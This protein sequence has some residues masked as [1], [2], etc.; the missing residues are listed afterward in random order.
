FLAKA[1]LQDQKQIWFFSYP[2]Q[3]AR[4]ITSDSSGYSIMSLSNDGATIAVSKVDIISSIWSFNPQNKEMTQVVSEN[5]MQQG[6]GG[7]TH[8]PD[9]RILFA[10]TEGTRTHLWTMSEEGR[11]EKV[12]LGEGGDSIH[13]AISPDGKFVVFSSNNQDGW[14]IWKADID[15][16]NAVQLTR[17]NSVG[18]F[19]PQVLPDNKTVVFER[20]LDNIIK[21]KLMKVSLDGGEEQPLFGE[22]QANDAFPRV[23][24]D[25]K[26][27]AFT[28]QLFDAKNLTFQNILKIAEIKDNIIQTPKEA[29]IE[30]MGWNYRWAKDGKT[31]TYMDMQG[32]PNIFDLT[33]DG[34]KSRQLTNFNSGII[35]NFDWANDGKRLFI[36]RGIIN[37]DLILIKDNLK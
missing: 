13:P 22:N 3:E 29:K 4:Q 21:S 36:V 37:S 15:G 9:G 19:R 30:N 2:Q 10:K 28:T 20:R 25:A 18:D 12:L 34:N 8:L 5:R 24:S 26:R 23:S 35:L 14:K 1:S 17:Q 7:L 33:I 32:V 31:L 6:V 27:L 16:K 11:N